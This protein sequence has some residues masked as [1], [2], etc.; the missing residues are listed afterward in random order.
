LGHNSCFLPII[1]DT[2]L[3]HTLNSDHAQRSRIVKKNLGNT[4]RSPF[5]VI[6]YR[7]SARKN[8]ATQR[9]LVKT[10][11]NPV[12]E[13]VEAFRLNMVVSVWQAQGPEKMPVNP[14]QVETRLLSRKSMTPHFFL[15]TGS[16]PQK[17]LFAS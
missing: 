6:S 16:C 5:S 3:N 12:A 14:I 13:L 15:F 2:P 11:T 1:T 4:P 7:L 8:E 9:T 10:T 17:L